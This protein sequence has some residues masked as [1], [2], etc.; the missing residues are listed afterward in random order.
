MRIPVPSATLKIR[1]IR[2]T[3][4]TPRLSP[5]S[6][7]PMGMGSNLC[8][9]FALAGLVLA[10]CGCQSDALSID[11]TIPIRHLPFGG[12]LDPIFASSIQRDHRR[13]HSLRRFGAVDRPLSGR[14]IVSL[15]SDQAIPPRSLTPKAALAHLKTLVDVTG[16]DVLARCMVPINSPYAAGITSEEIRQRDPRE[17][18]QLLDRHTP[19]ATNTS[20]CSLASASPTICSAPRTQPAIQALATRLLNFL[21]AHAW[22]VVMPDGSVSTT[23]L[24]RP[25]EQLGL[26]QIGPSGELRAVRIAIPEP[27]SLGSVARRDSGDRRVAG[28]SRFLLQ[29]QPGRDQSVQ[30]HPPGNGLH[31]ARRAIKPPTRSFRNAIQEP[32]E[33]ALQ[34]D[35]PRAQRRQRHAR[36]ADRQ[37]TRSNGSSDRAAI[38]TWICGA[39]FRPA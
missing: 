1:A 36:S 7:K 8:A 31:A 24:I 11:A 26:L 27:A 22:T 28:R 15:Q 14:R 37:R 19:R 35:R 39:K 2:S 3:S 21:T 20:E 32:H 4:A 16:T 6:I 34:H 13:L 12:I 30:P 10:C 33:R 25:D 9:V 38:S 17:R 18:R 29:V 23:F 5:A